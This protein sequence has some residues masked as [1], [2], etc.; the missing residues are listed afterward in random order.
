MGDL[1][2][3]TKRHGLA[4]SCVGPTVVIGDALWRKAGHAMGPKE[5]ERKACQHQEKKQRVQQP[6]V[7]I[8]IAQ[9]E[10]LIKVSHVGTLGPLQLVSKN[11]SKEPIL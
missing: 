10:F 4:E 7:A 6:N 3:L 2:Q 8:R 9:F 1:G 5:G 11:R